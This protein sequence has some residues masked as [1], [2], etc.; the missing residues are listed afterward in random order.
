MATDSLNPDGLL[1]SNDCCACEKRKDD[2]KDI[3]LGT[4]KSCIL[5]PIHKKIKFIKG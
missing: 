1:I 5:D 3:H 4:P 2:M